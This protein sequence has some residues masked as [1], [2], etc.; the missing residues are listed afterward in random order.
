MTK[1]CIERK[2][3]DINDHLVSI[4]EYESNPY[5]F[6]EEIYEDLLIEKDFFED[7]YK[8]N[9]MKKLNKKDMK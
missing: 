8:E 9:T 2:L 1:G 3:E 6:V 7:L 4:Q 5:R